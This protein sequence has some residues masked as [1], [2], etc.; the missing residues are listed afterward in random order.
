MTIDV[1]MEVTRTEVHNDSGVV[2]VWG[3]VG[4]YEVMVA[5]SIADAFRKGLFPTEEKAKR[6]AVKK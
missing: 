3:Y 2:C 1:P 4:D 6:M 5:L